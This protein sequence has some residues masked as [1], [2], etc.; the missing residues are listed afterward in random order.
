MVQKSSRM[1]DTKTKRKPPAQI[2]PQQVPPDDGPPRHIDDIRRDLARR[3]HMLIS[4]QQKLWRSCR[5]RPCRRARHCIVP[6][7][8]CSNAEPLPPMSPEREALAR[9]RMLRAVQAA[10]ARA[11]ER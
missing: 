1:S 2:Q 7:G 9:A 5:E 6:R 11:G 4:D 10:L 3:I 8:R